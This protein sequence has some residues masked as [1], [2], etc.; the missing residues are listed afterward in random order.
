MLKQPTHFFLSFLIILTLGLSA[1]SASGTTTQPIPAEKLYHTADLALENKFYKQAIELFTKVVELE[2]HSQ[3]AEKAWLR[4]ITAYQDASQVGK[5]REAINEFQDRFP[6]TEHAICLSNIEK[7]LI[8]KE[9]NMFGRGVAIGFGPGL[10][11]G[12]GIALLL[13]VSYPLS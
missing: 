13:C 12:F 6:N 4:I 10:V 9:K 2:G 8:Q 7:M 11:T 5:A 1:V 3:L